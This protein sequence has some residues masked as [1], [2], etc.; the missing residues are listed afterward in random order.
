MRM[1]LITLL[2]FAGLFMTALAAW[3][4]EVGITNNRLENVTYSGGHNVVYGSDGVGHVVWYDNGGGMSWAASAMS[5]VSTGVRVERPQCDMQVAEPKTTEWNSELLS[6]NDGTFENYFSWPEPRNELAVR[7]FAPANPLRPCR[8]YVWLTSFSGSD[9]AS[10]VRIYGNDGDPYG[11]PGTLIDKYAGNLHT[12]IWTSLY[13][14]Q[15]YFDPPPVVN[16]DTFFV[17]YYQTSILPKY[18]YLGVDY[19][20]P[21]TTDNDWG[22]Y[23]GVWGVFPSD[24][25]MDFGIDVEVCYET[26]R[27]DAATVSIDA[28]VGTVC[29]RGTYY[30]KATVKNLSDIP[31][32]FD[33]VFSIADDPVYTST[34]TTPVLDPNQEVQLTF[35]DPW[36]PAGAGTFETK[37]TTKLDGD[38]D[39]TNDR[40][41]GTVKVQLWPAGW[42]EMEPVPFGPDK[43]GIKDGA[44]LAHKPW[45]E[46]VYAIKGDR[47]DEFYR[48]DIEGN[49][50]SPL[51]PILRG[52]EDKLP[53]SGAR[54]VRDDGVYIYAT[55]G[56]NTPGFWRYDISSDEWTQ[57][58]DVPERLHG[59]S[60]VD[61]GTDVTYVPPDGGGGNGGYVYLL[62]GRSGEFY[63]YNVDAEAWE[64][65][66]PHAPPATGN[67][68]WE[69]GSYITYDGD[70]TIYAYRSYDMMLDVGGNEIW[71]FDLVTQKWSESPLPGIPGVPPT[72]SQDGG[73]GDWWDGSVWTLKGG[74]TREFWRYTPPIDWVG[75]N[76]MP[77]QGFNKQ[78]RNVFW[79]GD[80]ISHR[81]GAFFAF[82]GHDTPEF[83]R[84]VYAPEQPEGGQSG[85]VGKSVDFGMR[86]TLSPSPL[87]GKVLRVEYSLNQA[88]PANVTLFD[89]TGRAVAKGNFIGARAGQL[90]LD[91]YFLSAG[92][93]L[94]RLDD[95]HRALT[96]KLIIE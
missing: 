58:A 35:D 49:A 19:S 6:Y 96:Q 73:C 68:V 50:W 74:D 28:P 17:S 65:E 63:R 70:K 1:K 72:A 75:L 55:K 90:S 54:G 87:T 62:K 29:G 78:P 88:G 4:P 84:Y 14:N 91:L 40:Q 71:T 89:I 5:V 31:Q 69:E 7:F 77:K 61:G 42:V 52:R 25:S 27:L 44:W 76:Q 22:K 21:V 41:I 38:A 37:C 9:Y 26:P 95:G 48:Y 16:Y 85:T 83:W 18:P 11:N 56:A 93:Y 10:E 80:I 47:T 12:R 67:A 13:K 57:L 82:K 30:P 53:Y 64:P 8:V 60:K 59:N 43:K 46:Y 39:N 34:K 32:S 23:N 2:A 36:D 86:L 20:Q 79:G 15:V 33:V 66:L 94:V 45:D 24:A 81:C 92:V 51:A 3:G